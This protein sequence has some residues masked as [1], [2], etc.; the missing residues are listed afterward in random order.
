MIGAAGVV[1]NGDGSLTVSFTAS[2]PEG[3]TVGADAYISNAGGATF[4]AS[5]KKSVA[6]GASGSTRAFTWSKAEA[7][8]FM[9]GGQTYAVRVDAFDRAAAAAQ[10]TTD[11]FT[12]TAAAN[13][14]PTISGL[15]ASQ[16]GVGQA[17]NGSFLVSGSSVSLVRVHAGVSASSSTC[18]TDLAASTGAK[19]FSFTGN[20]INENG[21]D[22]ASLLPAPGGTSNIVFKVEAR[23]SAS[24]LANNGTAPTITASYQAAATIAIVNSASPGTLQRNVPTTVTVSGANL[25]STVA[26]AISNVVCNGNYSRSSISVSQTC[27]AQPGTPASVSLTVK[28]AAGGNFLAN[29]N[30]VI[31][32]SVQ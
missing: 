26:F 18:Y 6:A 4:N 22:C 7:D 1:Q 13:Q 3:G 21:L 8:S 28:D 16:S 15:S 29:G 25:P 23:D 20:W 12:R 19:S 31:F 27:T 17:I 30:Q 2:D 32:F 14:P 5:S 9:T 11:S 24:S 10:R